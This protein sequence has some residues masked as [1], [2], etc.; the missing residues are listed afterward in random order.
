MHLGKNCFI[1]FD[2]FIKEKFLISWEFVLIQ[3]TTLS[4]LRPN[5]LV[6]TLTPSILHMC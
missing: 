5:L 4:C 6:G 2:R 3:I 1:V